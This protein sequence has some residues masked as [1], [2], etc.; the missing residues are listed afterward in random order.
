MEFIKMR[1]LTVVVNASD[2][3]MVVRQLAESG[4]RDCFVVEHESDDLLCR[5]SSDRNG[6]CIKIEAVA[7]DQIAPTI[8]SKLEGSLRESGAKQ[9]TLADIWVP[10]IRNDTDRSK[11]R[12][13]TRDLEWAHDLISM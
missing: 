10:E 7:P 2:R 4:A 8:A 12:W 11:T 6:R 9:V 3:E 1:K 13:P 5:S